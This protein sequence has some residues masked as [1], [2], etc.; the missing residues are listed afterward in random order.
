MPTAGSR[1]PPGVGDRPMQLP[2]HV[3]HAGRG[4]R[5]APAQRDPH[6]RGNHT[7]GRE[8]RLDGHPDGEADRRRAVR[9]E[10][11]R[12]AGMLSEID[13]IEDLSVTTNGFMLERDAER[14]V[15]AGINRFNVSVD[16]LQ[17]YALL[18][19]DPARRARPGAAGWEV[20]AFPEA[21]PIKINAL[22]SA[23]S[24][25]R[26]YCR[27]PSWPGARPTTCGSS[28]CC[29]TPTTPGLRINLQPR[30]DPGR[31]RGGLSAGAVAT[32]AQRHRPRLPV[33]RRPGADRLDLNPVSEPFCADCNRVRLTADGRLRTCR[34]NEPT[35]A[36]RCARRRLRRLDQIIRAAVKPPK[37]HVG[38][39]GVD[40]G[41]EHVR[42]RRL[43]P[44]PCARLSLSS[45]GA[46][47]TRA[48]RRRCR[49]APWGPSAR[50]GTALPRRRSRTSVRG[51]ATIE[52]LSTGDCPGKKFSPGSGDDRRGLDPPD[53]GRSEHELACQLHLV[54]EADVARDGALGDVEPLRCR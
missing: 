22:A 21:H 5:V 19:A 20:A 33:R 30:R 37:H 51:S 47:G 32:R 54:I 17:R 39:R 40:R 31:D 44:G 18:R 35:C 3:L 29:S 49:C 4:R 53:D 28:R 6:L 41:A 27:L 10:F 46:G 2:L 24:P 1:R 11:P 38:E 13:A 16:S 34:L 26:R 42:D 48:S 52:R 25:S 15:A 50:N 43:T 12:L 14:L 45:P 23:A 36:P 8:F 7:G 9:R